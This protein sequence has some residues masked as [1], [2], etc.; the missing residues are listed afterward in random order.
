MHVR[1]ATVEDV[2]FLESPALRVPDFRPLL[3]ASG[4]GLAAVAAVAA[5]LAG[6]SYSAGWILS[7]TL[8]THP[9][10]AYSR[11][12]TPGGLRA[13]A[14]IQSAP[15]LLG[16]TAYQPHVV[17]IIE[18]P[19]DEP[20]VAEAPAV[21]LPANPPLLPQR[22]AA[23]APEPVPLPLARPRLEIAQPRP[24]ATP[25]TTV[26]AQSAPVQTPKLAALPPAGNSPLL[27][28]Y[29]R[30]A[31]YDISAHIVY[32]PNGRRLEAHSGI[33]ERMDDPRFI[34][35][36][37]RGPTPPN[38]YKLTLREALFHGVQAIRL[39]PVD[40]GRMHG[41]DGMLAHTYM[42]GPSGQSNGCVSFRDYRAFLQAYQNG[43]IDKLIVVPR[44]QDAPPQLVQSLRQ[45]VAFA[46]F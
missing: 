27:E 17:T 13:L 32:L 4:T 44:L 43:E 14:L 7:A 11:A 29:K 46:W 25:A 45:R 22:I 26:A 34:N 31:V 36:K 19:Q 35:V 2:S 40:Y 21:M 15:V 30:T 10:S 6:A 1:V 16:T 23:A 42:L 9:D 41:R 3:R 8:S 39:N 12:H 33:G 38:E 18:T 20:K 5:M 28:S 24:Q 37:M